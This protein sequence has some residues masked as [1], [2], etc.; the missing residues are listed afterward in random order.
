MGGG[1]TVLTLLDPKNSNHAAAVPALKLE[2][3]LKQD[4]SGLGHKPGWF[5]AG[6]QR[7]FGRCLV[8]GFAGRCG[9]WLH[10]LL[11]KYNHGSSAVLP[12]AQHDATIRL[13]RLLGRPEADPFR[14]QSFEQREACGVR[15][16]CSRFLS[17]DHVPCQ[18]AGK[19]GALHALRDACRSARPL[20]DD[21]VK[22]LLEAWNFL[23]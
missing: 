18:S 23:I 6:I 19:P 16:A 10:E 7:Q 4:R 20:F 1:P 9:G 22:T 17:G 21:F 14:A 15:G 8:A 2:C 3:R 11:H 12:A 5:C 13:L